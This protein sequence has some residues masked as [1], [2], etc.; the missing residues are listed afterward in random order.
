MKRK[1]S[2]REFLGWICAW[3]LLAT[4]LTKSGDAE[5]REPLETPI[6][7]D[8]RKA[9][10]NTVDLLTTNLYH[11]ARGESDVANL[12]IMA[13]VERRRE[14][15]GRYVD[16]SYGNIYEGVIFKPHSFSWTNDGMSDRMYNNAQYLRLQELTERFLMEKK[17]YMEMAKGADHYVKAG[18]PTNWDYSKLEFLFQIDN[19][20]FYK[21][22]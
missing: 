12:M 17:V 9:P 22:K 11:E 4:L 1:I 7:T 6:F 5:S 16:N 8:A 21:H 18:H 15:G 13:V 2:K 10:L 19:H 3:G 14:L 20:F